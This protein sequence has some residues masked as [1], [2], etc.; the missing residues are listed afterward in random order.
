MQKQLQV[1]YAE[2]L[3]LSVT[4]V[5]RSLLLL[6]INSKTKQLLSVVV[7]F[8]TSAEYDNGYHELRR[9]SACPAW[10]IW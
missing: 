5:K 6:A 9:F 2:L 3:Q 1:R 7:A 10:Y 8:P 4:A